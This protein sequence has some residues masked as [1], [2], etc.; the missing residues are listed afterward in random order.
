MTSVSGN[1]SFRVQLV[2]SNNTTIS[3]TIYLDDV[4]LYYSPAIS[5]ASQWVELLDNPIKE[6]NRDYRL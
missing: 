3:Q 2:V 6:E 5:A 1:T 4:Q